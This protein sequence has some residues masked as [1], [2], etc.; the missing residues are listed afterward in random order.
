MCMGDR[1][2]GPEVE[3][4][5]AAATY[6]PERDEVIRFAARCDVILSLE[7]FYG[8]E[9]LRAMRI[10]GTLG[11]LYAMPELSR[12]H[13]IDAA[14][15]TSWMGRSPVIPPPMT[16]TGGRS[17]ADRD[18]DILHVGAEAML[19]REGTEI[20]IALAAATGRTIHY[21]DDWD[22]SNGHLVY[23]PRTGRHDE[24]LDL[25]AR[26]KL[27]LQ[28]RRYGG[29][30]LLAVEAIEQGCAVAHPDWSPYGALRP[31]GDWPLASRFET[32]M[33][34]D[35]VPVHHTDP[36]ALAR[37]LDDLTDEQVQESAD[38]GMDWA[39]HVGANQGAWLGWL[40]R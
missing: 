24:L 8:R 38:I 5:P 19:D 33:K 16:V 6:P 2:R 13:G 40:S 9:L 23:H 25:M 34:G 30:S 12:V 37:Y 39:V 36:L 17:W 1:A 10:F 3:C 32:Q 7:T 20:V 29:L 26:T 11:K 14:Y 35:L 18:I 27:L 15:P 31:K 28:P 4:H 21:V 22:K